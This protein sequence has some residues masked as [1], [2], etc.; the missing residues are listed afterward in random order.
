MEQGGQRS[1]PRP[2]YIVDGA[3]T[4]FL[5]ARGKPGPF[6]A[7]DLAVAAG[8]PLLARQP[9]EPEMLSEVILGCVMPGPDE[10]NIARVAALRLGIQDHIPAW[11]V[12]RNCASGMQALDCA[13]LDIANDRASLVLA[14]GVEAMSHA[15]VLLSRPLVDWLGDWNQA[16]NI[17]SRLRLLG[18][19][20]PYH[21]R[22]IIG[23]LRG[24][25]D[26]VVG[27]S[28]GQ[29]AEILASRFAID[30]QA[31]DTYALES[32]QRLA[33]AQDSGWLNEVIPMFAANGQ[34]FEQDDGLRRDT[35]IAQLNKLKPVFD[36]P[37]GLVTAGNSAQVTDGACWLL[38]ASEQA[39]TQHQLPVIGRIV[40]SQWAALD[41]AQMGLGPVHA[42]TPLLQRHQLSLN[43]LDAW[44]LNEAFATQ[45]LACLAAWQ[46]SG[47]CRDELGLK[48][49]FGE[50]D[51][52]RLNVDG[53]AVALGHPVGA[54]GARIVLHLLHVLKRLN[55][56][57]GIATICIGGGQGGA[58]LLERG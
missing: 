31:M 1:L 47:Y 8:R 42:T 57:R 19:L 36:R 58:M 37:Y 32:H 33:H 26:P 23:L 22:P 5:K 24:L 25:T 15:P 28:M 14:G 54:S 10:A 39:V 9:F 20:R 17:K 21:L 7:T 18:R 44:E 52:K 56:Q 4:P 50:L 6:T 12:Q 2:V 40:D 29:T 30:R 55:G 49:T 35:S 38:L 27:L 53:G 41:P 3:R 34:F 46:D 43:D 51:R 48:E 45:V 13:A 16:R 11:T